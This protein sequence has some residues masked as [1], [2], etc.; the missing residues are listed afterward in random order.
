MKQKLLL[1]F[2]MQFFG[3]F[4]LA[5]V[6]NNMATSQSM[7]PSSISPDNYGNGL[8]FYDFNQ[9][10]WDDLSF[11]MQGDSQIFYI[12][13]Q[14]TFE[15]TTFGF[16][17]A[18][19]VK[20]LLW[21][22]YDNDHD[23]DLLMSVKEEIC[24]LYQND[25][26][27]NFTDVTQSAGL[28]SGFASNYGVSAADINKDGFLDILVC[29]YN[30]DGTEISPYNK[31]Y[32][33][34]G[35]GTFSDISV[36]AGFHNEM[37]LSFIG[38]FL[39]FDMD[40]WPDIYIINDR[41][42][43]INKLYRNNGDLSFTEVAQSAGVGMNGEDPMTASVADFDNDNDLD[44]F[45]SNTSVYFAYKPKLFTNQGN[46]TFFEEAPYYG[47]NVDNTSWGGLWLDYNN[48]GFQDLYVATAFLST[49]ALPVRS[50][51]LKNRFPQSF[52]DDTAAF[53]GNHKANSHAV[54][55][56]DIDNDGYYDIAVTNKFPELPFLWQNSGLT[57]KY[58]K[59]SLEGTISNYQAIGSWIRVYAGGQQYNQYTMCG[60]NYVGQNSQHFIFGLRNVSLVD[61]VVVSYPSGIVDKYY[62]LNHGQHYY[63]VEGET[64]NFDI[65]TSSSGSD[66]CFGDTIIYNA[67][68]SFASYLW[69]TGDT[70]SSIE[71]FNS[72]TY[73][74]VAY[75]VNNLP[76]YSDSLSVFFY[77]EPVIFSDLSQPSCFGLA[78]GFIELDI[79]NQGQQY[80]ITWNTGDSTIRIENLASGSYTYTYIDEFLCSVQDLIS[81]GE[82]FPLNVQT[83]VNDETSSNLGSIQLVINGGTFPYEVYL[84]HGLVSVPIEDLS[85]GTFYL[86]VIDA[87]LCSYSDSLTVQLIEDSV[88]NPIFDILDLNLLDVY[89]NPFSSELRI[90]SSN[91]IKRLEL[92]N[93]LGASYA[94]EADLDVYNLEYLSPGIY[95]L[96][97]YWENTSKMVK[98]EKTKSK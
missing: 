82:P 30:I 25:G 92:I 1:V 76:Y 21:L 45:T 42:S 8:S 52:L 13:N 10:G 65:N 53:V 81:L 75:D 23:M 86:E 49:N 27:F 78:D 14:G 93:S 31:L 56:G 18:R 47:V 68:N 85:A 80:T 41:S 97:I 73:W 37:M 39:D 12:N 59:I 33:N 7:L 19:N 54:A 29:R 69:N 20:Q 98:I 63:F 34:N 96:K 70:T 24:Y 89:P 38:V 36:Q 62:S 32:L 79:D 72:G 40:S 17:H 22:D 67:P 58:I 3:N 77:E 43:G 2:S 55:R 5:Q 6:F 74:L 26:N 94:L 64:Y 46:S 61:S 35:D 83:L 91:E 87:N 9:D 88:I 15:R 51:L 71:V 95:Y 16:F 28:Y 84:N 44:V 60:E 90:V 50:Y 48:D 66:F 57:N 4:L 11:A